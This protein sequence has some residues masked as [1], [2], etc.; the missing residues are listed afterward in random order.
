MKD[1]EVIFTRVQLYNGGSIDLS[2]YNILHT[3][4]THVHTVQTLE[5]SGR[6]WLQGSAKAQDARNTQF[7]KDTCTGDKTENEK[8]KK[9]NIDSFS[10]NYNSEYKC[11]W[12]TLQESVYSVYSV[13]SVQKSLTEYVFVPNSKRSRL[14]FHPETVT[15]ITFSPNTPRLLSGQSAV[16]QT[17]L[18]NFKSAEVGS[19]SQ[20][21]N[22][23]YTVSARLCNCV[24]IDI[25]ALYLAAE[26]IDMTCHL[27]TSK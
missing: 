13:Q 12:V 11:F 3:M 7:N 14:Y 8:T 22:L 6:Y 27:Y 26:D 16:Q 1:S 9:K 23:F 2:W 20:E 18:V 19:V 25:T 4:M 10:S 17:V 15:A 5:A 21:M 24:I